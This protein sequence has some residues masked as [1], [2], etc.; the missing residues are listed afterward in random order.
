M[1]P[2]YQS[3]KIY[4][5]RSKQTDLVYIGST[6]QKL[7]AR[8]TNHRTR[9]DTTSRHILKYQDAWIELIKDFPC[10]T[11]DELLEE[12]GKYIN[13]Y[14]CV[15]RNNPCKNKTTFIDAEQTDNPGIA[16]GIGDGSGSEESGDV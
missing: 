10:N 16:P 4:A 15:N 1:A 5:I 2:N 6:T 9:T 8:L 12:E 14:H 13:E 3:A 11:L 7:S